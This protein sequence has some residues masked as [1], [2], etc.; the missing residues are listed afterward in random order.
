[1][2]TKIVISIIVCTLTMFW[3]QMRIFLQSMMIAIEIYEKYITKNWWKSAPHGSPV[4]SVVLF[5]KKGKFSI[6]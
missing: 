5:Y 2:K 1:M 4:T 3:R 6:K